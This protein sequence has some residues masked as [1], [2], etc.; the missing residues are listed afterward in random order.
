[1]VF[2]GLL[3]LYGLKY[4]SATAY[5][6]PLYLCSYKL[7]GFAAR[8]RSDSCLNNLKRSQMALERIVSPVKRFSFLQQLS[9]PG[10]GGFTLI[11]ASHVGLMSTS[12]FIFFLENN[13]LKY[14]KLK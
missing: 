11:L 13:F 14:N 6:P 12:N 2:D 3:G 9:E 5:G 4:D 1:M 7:I 10:K 8:I